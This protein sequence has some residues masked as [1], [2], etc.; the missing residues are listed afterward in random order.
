V[1]G[2]IRK[3]IR[4]YTDIERKTLVNVEYLPKTP[5][6]YSIVKEPSLEGGV[7]RSFISGKKL[8]EIRV[9]LLRNA[10]FEEPVATN[11]ANAKFMDDFENWIDACNKEKQL[12]N[13]TGIQSV[14][15]T[16]VGYLNA[17]AENQTSA[18]Y[19]VGLRFT[20]IE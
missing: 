20:Y 17:I 6:S 9:R 10:H 4:G 12:P 5:I 11:I 13:I 19:G 2:E 16:T 15:I 18:V 7:I 3:F 8:K 14:E 1:L